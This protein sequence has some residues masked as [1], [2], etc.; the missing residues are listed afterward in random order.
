M[1]VRDF[2][3]VAMRVCEGEMTCRSERS[4]QSLA[5]LPPLEG[6]KSSHGPR[7]GHG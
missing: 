6:P 3:K 4:P 2:M 1:A 5:P 7:I